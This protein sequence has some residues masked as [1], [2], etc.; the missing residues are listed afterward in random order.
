[1]QRAVKSIVIVGGGIAG[2]MT[3]TALAKVFDRESCSIR[4]IESDCGGSARLNEGTVPAIHDFNRRFDIDEQALMRA[5]NATFKLGT[6]FEDW[7]GIGESYMHTY[8]KFGQEISGVGFQHY[9]LKHKSTDDEAPIG[10]FAL[11]CMAAKGG[12][13]QHPSDDPRSVY[14]TYS[15]AF[16]LDAALYVNFLRDIA[17]KLGVKRIN[18]EVVDVQLGRE[19]GFIKSVVLK[20]GETVDGEFFVD[21]SG[22]RSLLIGDALRTGYEDWRSWLPFDSALVVQTGNTGEPLPYTQAKAHRAG[23]QWRIP[24]Q[25]RDGRGHIYS[26]AYLSDDAATDMLLSSLEDK[27]LTEPELVRFTPGKRLNSWRRNCVAI[28][29]SDGFL[30]PLESTGTLLI[31]AAITKFIEYFPDADFPAANTSAYNHQIESMYASVRDFI[32]LHFKATRRDD[33]KYWDYCREMSV[34]EELALRME[35]F[36]S[37]GVIPQRSNEF[38]D[39]SSWL[40]VFLG[41]GI[42]PEDCDPRTDRMPKEQALQ[43]LANMREHINKAANAMPSHRQAIIDYCG[44]AT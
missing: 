30:G 42:V 1:M 41:Q 44:S 20:S 38:F 43:H 37:R 7:G 29:S 14:S 8:G 24:L 33:S 2:W 36:A 31:H 4:L 18:D 3:A 10:E 9:W 26:S 12:R 16:H 27:L 13:F 25:H 35:L 5:T 28:G 11:P 15:Y 17:E 19:D 6:E 39:E 23:W 40:A 32:I 21:C 22:F 34:P